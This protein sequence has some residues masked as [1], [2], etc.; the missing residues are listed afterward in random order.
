VVNNEEEEKE[1]LSAYFGAEPDK[2]QYARFFLM[3]QF[4]HMSYAAFLLLQLSSKGEPIDLTIPKPAFREFH[5][6]MWKGKINLATNPPR[7]QYAL[8]HIEQLLYNCRQPRFQHSLRLV[9]G[10]K[11]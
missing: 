8:L 9:E 5:E 1:F 3:R 10:N 4:L 2:Y 6:G 7:L 11:L